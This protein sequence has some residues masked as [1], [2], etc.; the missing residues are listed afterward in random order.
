MTVLMQISDPHFGTEQPPVVEALLRLVHAQAPQLIVM[1]GDLTQRAHR[2]E[3]TAARAFVDRCAP[4]PTLAIPGNHDIA[5]FNVAARAF[6]PY[7]AYRHA[8]GKTLEPVHVSDELLV[9]CVKTTRRYRHKD[10]DVSDRQIQRVSRQLERA[11]TKQLRVVVTHQPVAAAVAADHKNLLHGREKAIAAWA[12]AGVDLILGGHIHLPY[13]MPLADLPRRI[14]AVQA[15][16]AVSTR[17]RD[18]VPNSINLIRYEGHASLAV[19][20]RWDYRAA[21]DAFVPVMRHA[22]ALGAA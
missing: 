16:T 7:A 9:L 3:F 19:V 14:Y 22:L 20:E 6:Y 17:V 18:G 13:V 10:G 8:F 15:G 1:S 11:T 4:V 12:A 21:D 2:R 5:L